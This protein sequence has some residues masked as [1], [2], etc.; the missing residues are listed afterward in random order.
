MLSLKIISRLVPGTRNREKLDWERSGVV[1][2]AKKE[3]PGREELAR[4]GVATVVTVRPC[5]L[6]FSVVTTPG[7]IHR[8]SLFWQRVVK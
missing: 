4:Q 2:E 1:G 8:Y 7:D 3:E 6:G 5:H